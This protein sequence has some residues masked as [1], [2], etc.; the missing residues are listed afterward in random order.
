MSAAPERPRGPHLRPAIGVLALSAG[1]V[2]MTVGA[3]IFALPG[4]AAEQL[5][6]QAWIA[7][8]V[9]AI[10]MTSVLLCF[11]VAGSLIRT[12]GGPYMYVQV[13]F[14]AFPA[15]L[16][17]VLLWVGAVVS[18]AAVAVVFAD[19]L[20][21]I[22]PAAATPMGRVVVLLLIYAIAVG[23]NIRGVRGGARTVTGF[24]L[25]KLLPLVGLVL[26]AGIMFALG[27]V[28]PAGAPS[29]PSGNAAN[30]TAGSALTVT[31]IGRT[32]LVL[33]FA[34]LGAEVALA[35]SGEVE[36][37]ARTVPVAIMIALT[38][39]T[40]LYLGLQGTAQAVLGPALAQDATINV[41]PIAAVGTRLFGPFG[42]TVL[43]VA[44][45]VSTSGYVL[46]DVLASPR[47][48]YALATD[49][50]LPRPFARLHRAY[51]TP[52]ISIAVHGLL[53]ALLAMTGTFAS[54]AILN[55]VA[56]LVLYLVCCLAALVLLRRYATRPRTGAEG[57]GQRPF[58]PPLGPL[59]PLM[60]C[61]VVIWLLAQAAP[62]EYAAV[63]AALVI[64]TPAYLLKRRAAARDQLPGADPSLPD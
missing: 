38:V 39:V 12:S 24:T 31:T 63:G 28:A 61:G 14:G 51:D 20:G 6:A 16:A 55:N 48:L 26:I 25:A 36:R 47:I 54:L 3:G 46:G 34:F 59:V 10:A 52:A 1:I 29:L 22:L 19:M 40:L 64:A 8:V 50:Y 23:I 33:I 9:C 58:T 43:T 53:A 45:L 5:G 32:A 7:Y 37:P 15:F 42:A 13:A 21:A 35:P 62:Q 30:A 56:I 4:K 11:A 57:A 18:S 27:K 60:A 44:A 49:G 2:N 17:G 41:A